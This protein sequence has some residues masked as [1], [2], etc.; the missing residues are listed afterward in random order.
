[1]SSNLKKSLEIGIK[2]DDQEFNAGIE[3]MQK[4]L[5]DMYAPADYAR[6]QSQLHQNLIAAGYKEGLPGY[7]PGKQNSERLKADLQSKKDIGEKLESLKKILLEEKILQSEKIKGKK[8]EEEINALLEK[9]KQIYGELAVLTSKKTETEKKAISENKR[10]DSEQQKSSKLEE[11]IKSA[12]KVAAITRAVV[13][14]SKI[15]SDSARLPIEARLSQ[16]AAVETLFSERL[17]S[18]GTAYGQAFLPERQKAI[19]E[20]EKAWRGQRKAEGIMGLSGALLSTAGVGT[21]ALGGLTGGGSLLAGGLGLMFGS[22]NL[23]SLMLGGK[24]SYEK[25]STQDLANLYKTAE[26][27]EEKANPLKKLAAEFYSERYQRNLQLQRGMGLTD[28]GLSRFFEKGMAPFGASEFTEEQVLSHQQA[29]MAAGGS[30]KMA[31]EAGYGLSLEKR[32]GLTNA[33]QILGALSHG[34]GG[35]GDT[36]EAAVKILEKAFSRGLNSS[37]LVD[38][39]RVFSQATTS[40]VSAS[41]ART[42]QDVSRISEMM[43]RALPEQTQ[44]GVE[45]A[46]NA[47]EAYQSYTSQTGGVFGVMRTSALMR[48]KLGKLLEKGEEGQVVAQK[49]L[50]IPEAMRTEGHPAVQ[51]AMYLTGMTADEV[52]TASHE[53]ERQSASVS[54]SFFYN[55]K[56]V[57]DWK[58]ANPS[59]AFTKENIQSGL[60]PTDIAQAQ[61]MTGIF[62]ATKGIGSMYNL[63]T[64]QDVTAAG[65]I[66][67]EAPE[68]EKKF[69]GPYAEGEIT[70]SMLALKKSLIQDTERSGDQTQ[71]N[72]SATQK[73][74]FDNF[75]SFQKELV[76]TATDI[77]KVTSA[78]VLLG[79]AA[80]RFGEKNPEVVS[81][82]A[83]SLKNILQPQSAPTP[84]T[85]PKVNN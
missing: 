7:Q 73:V 14:V 4:R 10:S 37:E 45:S 24:D 64:A 8:V 15:I 58:K 63:S 55:R 57:E 11:N 46:K 32:L 74:F 19:Q 59:I 33:P 66:L 16:G 83:V 50:S 48:G 23:R 1:M 65:N 29:L 39:L 9:R 31:R 85:S 27:S 49:L 44:A 22:K 84:A 2:L 47:M 77:S 42:P 75:N 5:K 54:G 6:A 41:G 38:V 60:I 67:S 68:E 3:R 72:I 70:P 25:M 53:I 43:A 52:I 71:A 20:A 21:L 80:R 35:S 34:M 40:L 30:A 78:L 12:I 61:R 51:A 81:Q 26:A 56:K 76:P 36:E 69:Y 28:S 79:E 13:E 62:A 17:K 18:T 82:T